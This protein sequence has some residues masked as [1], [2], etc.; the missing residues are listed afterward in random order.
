[1]SPRDL[2]QIQYTSGTTGFPKGVLLYHHALVNNA[3]FTMQRMGG[4]LTDVAVWPLP[5]FHTAGLKS[6]VLACLEK[7]PSKRPQ[8]ASQLFELARDCRTCEQWSSERARLW[9][10]Q[11][12][13]ELTGPLTLQETESQVADRAVAIH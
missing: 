7:D 1:M 12:L 3:R 9:W 8:D 13:L 11:H 2:A 10:E 4:G 6:V 5:L